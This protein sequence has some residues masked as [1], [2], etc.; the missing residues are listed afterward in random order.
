MGATTGIEWCHHTFNPWV[1]CEKVSPG[2]D[3]CY[4]SEGTTARISRGKGLPL[5]GPEAE[6][7]QKAES[8]WA[9]P[10][11]WFRAAVRAGERRL[12]FCLSQGDV[13]EKRRDL[14]AP[15][16]RLWK[17]IELAGFGYVCGNPRPHAHLPGSTECVLPLSGGLDWLLLT[18]RPEN[19]LR[20]MPDR[21]RTGLP[22]NVWFGVSVENQDAT[23]RLDDL[24][25]IPATVR[26]A[27]FEPLL[28]PID[29]RPWL[30]PVQPARL[31]TFTPEARAV[32]GATP[33]GGIAVARNTAA[34]QWAIIG[35]ESDPL[36]KGLARPCDVA[37]IRDLL[38]QLRAAGVP[39]FVKQWGATP[40]TDH[41]VI[42]AISTPAWKPV[43][44]R[45]PKG[46][47]PAEWPADL[48]VREFPIVGGA[49]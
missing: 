27:S 21:W 15:R 39:P 4:A 19:A 3:N 45:H 41:R 44:L 46:G 30:P 40:C 5:W 37:W 25:K 20:L 2:C 42:Q 17:L 35:G 29:A 16:E 7:Q 28:G 11:R 14:D 18:K 22:P 13:L 8:G 34:L 36:R 24:A 23:A 1:G 49:R 43:R 47:D 48:R 33:A 10:E 38:A 9:E 26:F 6:R 12:V 31:H 32:Y